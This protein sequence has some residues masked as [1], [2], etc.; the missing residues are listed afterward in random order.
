[1]GQYSDSKKDKMPKR[2]Y[3]GRIT[4]RRMPYQ[5][6]YSKR[7]RMS[8]G[9]ATMQ[10][11]RATRSRN[12]RTGGFL[13]IEYKFLDCAFNGGGTIAASTDATGGE[14]QPD[15][16][17]TNCISCPAQGDG[18]SNRDGRKYVIKS[19]WVSGSVDW[20]VLQDQIDVLPSAGVYMALVLDTQA[21]GATINTEDIFVNPTTQAEGMIPQPLRNLQNSKRFRILDSK[22]VSA[23]DLA[24][25]TDGAST[26]SMVPSSQPV[27]SL[28]WK[29]NIPV[30]CTGT[31]ADVASVSDNALH[32]VAFAGTSNYACTFRG[33]SRIRFVG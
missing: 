29:G 30:E 5:S 1:M 12:Y 14:L 13:G 21:N 26:M 4:K 16:G 19:A 18:E 15:S 20:G 31:T 32:V 33:K 11:L 2:T 22:Y 7:S 8:S 27:I 25:G 9:A 6:K 23:R 3:G 10:R 28:S 24:V 17:C